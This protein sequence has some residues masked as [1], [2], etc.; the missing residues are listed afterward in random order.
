[1]LRLALMSVLSIL[2][3]KID[4]NQ[5]RTKITPELWS[6]PKKYSKANLKKIP[7]RMLNYREPLIY[8]TLGRL[9]DA[10]HPDTMTSC[11]LA[12]PATSCL[13]NDP[14]QF[15]MY[16]VIVWLKLREC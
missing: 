3:E 13:Q 14:T 6:I 11:H 4:L 8:A 15:S 10:R 5:L 12:L 2:L 9:T 1:M 7:L 16:F